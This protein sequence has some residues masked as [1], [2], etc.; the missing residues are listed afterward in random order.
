MRFC[1]QFG[2]YA[3][4]CTVKP[5]ESIIKEK[6]FNKGWSVKQ[7]AER[8]EPPQSY[9]NLHRRLNNNTL[10]VQWIAMISSAME[11]DFFSDLS[12]EFVE[13][14]KRKKFNVDNV[15]MEPSVDYNAT[16]KAVEKILRE[17]GI[18]K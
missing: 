8:M 11:H 1:N 14:S 6:L 7:L 15:V 16:E 2:M 10:D 9:Q 18:I 17:K 13:D 12:R 5:V 3:G 4:I